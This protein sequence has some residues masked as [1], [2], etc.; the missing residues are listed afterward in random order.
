MDENRELAEAIQSELVAA[1]ERLAVAESST[2]GLVG[3]NITDIPGS[4]DYFDRSLV[5]Y[6]NQAKMDLLGVE[7]TTLEEAGAV[8]AETAQQMAAGVSESAAS[9]W[10]ISTTGI[11]GPTGGTEAKPVGTVFIGVAYN[12]EKERVSA[13]GYEFDGPRLD[14]KEQFARQALRD[15]LDAIES[16]E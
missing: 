10:G 5:T 4:S 1:G 7:Q 16:R 2:G 6:S 13:T 14:C 11:A 12:G 9:T 3:S 8:S 15:L